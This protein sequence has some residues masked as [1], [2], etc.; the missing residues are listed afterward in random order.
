MS[1]ESCI[2]PHSHHGGDPDDADDEEDERHDEGRDAD[3]VGEEERQVAGLDDRESEEHH[4]REQDQDDARESPFSAQCPDLTP[5]LV[6]FAD[7][8][9]HLVEHLGEV[10]AGLGVDRNRLGDPLEVIA[11]HPLRRHREGLGKVAAESNLV[12]DTGQLL[13]HRRVGLGRDGRDRAGE[14]VPGAETAGEQLDGVVDLVCELGSALVGPDDEYDLR[15]DG[16][17]EGE[18]DREDD[19]HAVEQPDHRAEEGEDARSGG[20]VDRV[21]RRGCLHAGEL[22]LLASEQ[23]A[24]TPRDDILCSGRHAP[25]Q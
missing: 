14:P 11:P 2:E 12:H 8:A 15:D 9:T 7:C 16:C 17:G 24:A 22:E 13:A 3:D 20:D 4:D 1:A 6:P 18:Q 19:R 25:E 23:P 5:D 10:A 21:L